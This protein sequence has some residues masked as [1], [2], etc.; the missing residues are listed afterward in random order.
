M[1]FGLI[2]ERKN[3]PDHRVVLT[4]TACQK[5]LKKY[6]QADI[7]VESSPIRVFSDEEYHEA[8]LPV[9]REMQDCEVL[10]GV[11]EVPIEALIPGKK[12]FFFSHTIKKQPYNRELLRAILRKKIELYDHEVL[13][14]PK[15][16][17][18]VAFGRYAGIVGA[19][20][21]FRAFGLK[22]GIFELPKAEALPDQAA[23]IRELRQIE[24][25]PVKILLTG[26]GRVGSGA[27]EMLDGM[28]LRKVAVHEYLQEDFNE[29]VY[30]QIDASFYNKR[31]DGV[32]GNKEE[33]IAHPELYESNFFR[34]A[35]VTD[36]FIAGH[37]YGEGAPYLITRED[38]Y[39]P[40]FRIR[41]IADISCDINGPVAPTIRASTIA[42]PVY[43]YDPVT[44]SET[45]FRNRGAVAVMAVDNLP[46]EL[47]RDASEGFGTAF[48]KYVIPAFFDGDSEGILER[49]RMT[50]EGAL[51]PRYAYLQ[52]YVDG[53]D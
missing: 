19:Y 18:L 4:P 47:P 21:G 38:V 49:A 45:D 44:R 12:Y 39:H 5:V 52:D 51:T 50:R 35:R 22:H 11:K 23:L 25:P 3:P 48:S 43:G 6:P 53:T 30:C 7:R 29:P 34:F 24:M 14:N 20:N 27:R 26:R 16:R 10:L 15:G 36:F 33:F 41:V 13:T 1:I 32:R 42:D 40:D 46:A 17:R 8:G 2:R 28:G 31:K 37:F 9:V